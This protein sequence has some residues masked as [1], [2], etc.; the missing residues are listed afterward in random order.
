MGILNTKIK[1]ILTKKNT[2]IRPEN[3]K[4]DINILGITG[5]YEGQQPTGEIEEHI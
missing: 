2:K 5:T 4:K 1:N 3:I